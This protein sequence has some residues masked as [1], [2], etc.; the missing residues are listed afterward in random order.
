MTVTVTD[1]TFDQQVLKSDK[2]VLV[3]F[4]AEWCGPCKVMEPILE[5]LSDEMSSQ[6]TIAKLDVDENLNTSQQY[7][8]QSIPTMIL[9]VNGKPVEELVGVTAK[10]ALAQKLTSAVATA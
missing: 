10:D 8:V 5:Q 7:N 6:L 9:F 1:E 2:P 4:W 3:D